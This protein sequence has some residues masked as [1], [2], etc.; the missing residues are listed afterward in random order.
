MITYTWDLHPIKCL[1]SEQG[2]NNVVSIIPWTYIGTDEYGKIYT[3]E[4]ST[5]M[6][7]PNPNV[8][9]PFEELT[10]PMVEEWLNN[11]LNVPALQSQVET[12]VA[13]DI[14][15]EQTYSYLTLKY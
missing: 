12:L 1:V 6:G 8:F 3:L 14:L 2:L 10:R 11:A 9:T 4:G 7:A 15:K 13:E 5:Q